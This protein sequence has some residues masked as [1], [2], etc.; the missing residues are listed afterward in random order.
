[1]P[2]KGTWIEQVDKRTHSGKRH[3]DS[4]DPKYFAVDVSI[5]S[6][7]YKDDPVNPNEQWKEID[8]IFEPA[9]APWDFEMVKAGYHIRVRVDFEAG[10]VIEFEKQG[11]TV[12]F[13][14]MALEWTNDLDQVQPISMPQPVSPMITNP[15]VDLLPA[16]GVLSHQGTIRWNDG[17]G[18]GIDFQWKCT[19]TRLVKIL[20]VASF[21]KL[22]IP[23]QYI[24]DGG[25]PVLR[26]NLIFA[27]SSG[28]NIYVDGELWDKKTKVQTFNVIEFRKNGEVLWGFMPLRYWGSNPDVDEN[29]GQ[30]IATLEKRGNKLYISIRVSY[31]WLQTAVYP[32]FIDTDVDEV[33]GAINEDAYERGNDSGFSYD[34]YT[35]YI[36]GAAAGADRRIGGFC[37]DVN[38][39]QGSIISVARASLYVYSSS[40]DD[41]YCDIYAND[42]DNANKFDAQQDIYNRTKTSSSI[43]WEADAIGAGWRNSPDFSTVVKE[44][45]DRANWVANN[46]ICILF[47]GKTQATTKFLNVR[48][49][50]VDAALAAKLHI[51]YTTGGGPGVVEGSASGLGIGLATS[52]AKLDVLAS[53][54]GNGIGIALASPHLIIPALASGHGI[55]LAEAVG[56]LLFKGMASGSGVGLGSAEALIRVLAAA[57]ASGEGSGSAEALLKVIAEAQGSGGGL[58]LAEALLIILAQVQASGIGSL[59]AIGTVSSPSAIEGYLSQII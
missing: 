6:I 5:G 30:S 7:H 52:E 50:K 11:E 51:E 46:I 34:T 53:A 36:R 20:E 3:V 26:L 54:L 27:P 57:A 19:S 13:Q 10:Q 22:P 41:P 9:V 37:W 32:V 58:G 55:G 4:A 45:I 48:G 39:P 40:Y 28:V 44:V 14:P 38:V 24:L 33:V 47:W 15:E 35:V 23:E 8:N 56:C 2:A 18:E 31:D 25:N 42:V 1:M 21:D 17:Y 16:V 12:Q 43:S 29:V 59:D 49:Y